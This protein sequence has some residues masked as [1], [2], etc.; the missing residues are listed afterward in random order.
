MTKAQTQALQA[1]FIHQAK[2]SE[3]VTSEEEK[4]TKQEGLKKA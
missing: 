2:Q 1:T 3:A 4:K